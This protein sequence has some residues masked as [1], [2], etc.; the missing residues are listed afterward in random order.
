MLNS[1]P[2]ILVVD[3]ERINIQIL[4]QGL[5]DDYGIIA[6]STG[7]DALRIAKEQ[8]PDL[9]LLDIMLGDINGYEVC[10]KLKSDHVTANIP[11]IF[12]TGRDSAEDELMG[13]EVGAVDYFRK[14]FSIP[15]ARMRISKQIELAQKTALLEHLSMVDG[16][17]G[18]ANRRQFDEKLE[19]A[20]RYVDR[21]DR[22][23]SL[24]LLDIDY[25]KQYNDLYGHVKGDEV[26]KTVARALRKGASR[27]LDFVARYGGE[28]FAVLLLDSSPDEGLFVADK[29]R[30]CV[31]NLNILHNGSEYKHLTTSVGVAHVTAGHE[32]L[33]HSRDLIE[34]ADQCLYMA[35]NEGRNRAISSHLILS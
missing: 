5:S 15:L 7:I 10:R 35:K 31:E 20:I 8:L 3:D 28:E 23:L 24:L 17:T 4:F 33:I 32:A 25:F 1:I 16:L 13:L 14:P 21:N 11:V 19:E 29:L 27:P 22:G 2:K 9:I 18:I 30:T 6:A 26:L 34:D 12:V